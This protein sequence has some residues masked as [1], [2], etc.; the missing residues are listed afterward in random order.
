MNEYLVKVTE[1]RTID[2]A[3]QARTKAE[4]RKLARAVVVISSSL[5]DSWPE[6][7]ETISVDDSYVDNRTVE[8]FDRVDPDDE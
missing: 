8:F 5:D 7:T 3:V 2:L 6:D 1:T 4:A